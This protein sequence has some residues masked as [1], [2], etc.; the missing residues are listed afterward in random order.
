MLVPGQSQDLGLKTK[1]QNGKINLFWLNNPKAYQQPCQLGFNA[2]G[3]I[4]P[5]PDSPSGCVPLPAAGVLGGRPS[6]TYGPAPLRKFDLSLFKAFPIS[7]HFRMEF[8][9]EF[10]NIL[11]HPNFNA[12]NFGGNGLHP[13][14]QRLE[15]S[16]APG[17]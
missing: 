9:S 2:D 6:T 16:G 1:V 17:R 15:L 10:F 5:Q 8:R 7:D 12:P 4:S 13:G 11:N 14:G 3:S